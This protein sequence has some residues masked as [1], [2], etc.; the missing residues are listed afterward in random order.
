MKRMLA[1]LLV[2]AFVLILPV[3]AAVEVDDYSEATVM[4]RL[5]LYDGGLDTGSLSAQITRGEGVAWLM[6]LIGGAH[7]VP[8]GCRHPFGD[9]PAGLRDAVAWA[10]TN[11]LTM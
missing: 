10:Y 2:L 8:A 3:G 1:M 4:S 5:G 6:R 11:G 9:V 7:T